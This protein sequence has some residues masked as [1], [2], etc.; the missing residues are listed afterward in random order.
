ML[1]L[2]PLVA[3]VLCSTPAAAG[4]LPVRSERIVS[5]LSSP[6][7]VLAPASENAGR[8]FIIEQFGRVRV[9]RDGNVLPTPYLDLTGQLAPG[10]ERG[11]LGMAFHPDFDNNGLV[12]VNYTNLDGD[13]VIDRYTVSAEDPD[14]VDPL[15]VVTM[16]GPVTQP[17]PTHNGGCMAFGHDGKLYIGIGD[18]GLAN[19]TGRGHV[20]GGNAQWPRTLLGKMLRMDVDIPYPHVPLDNPHQGDISTL[21]LIWGHGL[22]EPWRFSFDR[23]TGD[24]YIGDVGQA[25]REEI[26]FVPASFVP[27]NEEPLNFGWRCREGTLCTGLS[28]CSCGDLDL[29]EPIEEFDHT[30]GNAMIGGHVYRGCAIPSLRGYYIYSAFCYTAPSR[31]FAFSVDG[32][33]RGPTIEL[34]SALAPPAPLSIIN[35]TSFGEDALGELYMCD[36]DGEIYKILPA[37][38]MTD[39]NGNLIPDSCE[40]ANGTVPDSNDNGVPDTCEG[41]YQQMS[42]S[43]AIQNFPPR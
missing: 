25:Q 28:G 2:S 36:R 32:P 37:D 39:C 23:D 29:T 27:T 14:R 40:I 38:P 1:V 21:P 19:D 20:D 15:S 6:V 10:G 18:G 13:T 7:L 43:N 33:E 5:G 16:L 42:R 31:I 30:V 24:L 22:R 3:A 17:Q 34:T 8:L 4:D 41:V 11:L 9:M 12:Y 26:N 35:M